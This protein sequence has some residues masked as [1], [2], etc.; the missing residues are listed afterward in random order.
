MRFLYKFR[1][2]KTSFPFF[3]VYR[4]FQSLLVCQLMKNAFLMK[5][6]SRQEGAWIL[7]QFPHCNNTSSKIFRNSSHHRKKRLKIDFG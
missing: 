1:L 4:H 3:Y 2:M 7:D 6:Q 5:V